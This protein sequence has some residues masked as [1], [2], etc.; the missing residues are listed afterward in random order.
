M[1]LKLEDQLGYNL[2]RTAMLFRRELGRSLRPFGAMTPEQWQTLNT[3]WESPEGLSPSAISD[4]TLQDMPSIS[5]MVKRMEDH[6]WVIREADPEDR[7][8]FRVKLTARGKKLEKDVPDQLQSHFQEI[9]RSLSRTESQEL[10]NSLKKL[11]VALGDP[12]KHPG[13]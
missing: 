6:G 11:R 13:H 8:S 9:L 3:L 12:E 2:N 10:I 5:R 7:R 1:A 4:L